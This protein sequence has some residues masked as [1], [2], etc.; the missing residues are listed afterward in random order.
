MLLSQSFHRL[1][2]RSSCIHVPCNHRHHTDPHKYI[3]HTLAP[4]SVPKSIVMCCPAPVSRAGLGTGLVAV[5]ANT[6]T[7]RVAKPAV[8]LVEGRLDDIDT[9]R[10]LLAD[11][12]RIGIKM[13]Q[14]GRTCCGLSVDHESCLSTGCIDANMTKVQRLTPDRG[15]A[16]RLGDI[17]QKVIDEGVKEAQLPSGWV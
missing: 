17:T 13:P 15:I 6:A 5:S 7:K 4:D 14:G 3:P 2:T 9:L 12:D 16:S 10:V 1:R 8:A 11:P